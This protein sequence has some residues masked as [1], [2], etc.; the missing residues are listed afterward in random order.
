VALTL[1]LGCA[2]SELS[3]TI[4]QPAEPEIVLQG[5]PLVFAPTSSGF[6]LNVVVAQGER[7][8]L[9]ARVRKIGTSAWRRILARTFRANDIVEWSATALAPGTRYE[10][11][12]RATPAIEGH[13]LFSGAVT[14]ARPPG[15]PFTFTLISDSHIPPRDE[16]PIGP[17]SEG[18][19]EDTLAAVTREMRLSEPDFVINLGDILDF[20]QFG[21]NSPP[22]DGSYTRL[23]YLN[24]RRLFGE[25]LGNTAHF[26]VIGNWD[27]ENGCNTGEEIERSRTQRRLY[28]P[29]PDPNTYAEG[30]SEQED[31][32]AFR[33]GDALFV[34]LN[35]MTYTSTCHLL[36]SNPG[37][38]DDWTLGAAQLAWLTRT[39]A[40]ATA[41]WRFLFIHHTV[42]GAAGDAANSGYGRGGGLAAHVGE[43]ALIHELMLKYGVQIFFYGHDHVFTDMVVD[44]VHYTLP[45]SAGAPWKFSEEET[46]Y[47]EFWPESGYARVS[48]SAAQAQVEFI[49][50][51]GE[52]LSRY[53]LP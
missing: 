29:G 23:A 3:P 47:R 53:T 36:G 25:A 40:N 42:G 17:E 27:G 44:G 26:P 50:L 22:P 10:Y 4:E 5:P 37:R 46:G 14:T 38:P 49:A 1:A 21:F 13:S 33:S 8:A 41:K 31:F 20:H 18:F 34:V 16:L 15:T 51:G 28:L 19:M 45:G 30:G 24:Y 2:R 43:Q 35:V 6:S 39:L 32:Y 11:Q 12:I 52:T 7:A 9:E 48:V